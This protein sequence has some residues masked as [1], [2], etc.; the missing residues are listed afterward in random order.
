MTEL[1]SKETKTPE[2]VEATTVSADDVQYEIV[3][4]DLDGV[5]VRG[6]RANGNVL[7]TVSEAFTNE[8]IQ[9]T[10]NLSNKFFND[11]L[12]FGVGQ[13]QAQIKQVL[14][15][16]DPAPMPTPMPTPVPVPEADNIKTE[17]SEASL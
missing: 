12:R 15:I 9:E 4:G 17:N 7:F 11:G 14:G 8:Q 3:D 5:K 13:V 2:E 16:V 1:D 6:I 10:F